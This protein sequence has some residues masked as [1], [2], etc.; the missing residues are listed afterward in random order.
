MSKYKAMS[1]VMEPVDSFVLLAFL[2]LE[3][4]GCKLPADARDHNNRRL[5]TRIPHL[6]PFPLLVSI[7]LVII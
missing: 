5:K 3:M 6:F 4:D 2:T 7:K 1:K